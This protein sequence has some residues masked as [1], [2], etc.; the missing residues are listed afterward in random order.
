MDLKRRDFLKTGAAAALAGYSARSLAA[1]MPTG[2]DL[3][4]EIDILREALKLHPGL[5]RY[6]R[7]DE[8]DAALAKLKRRF[9]GANA[10]AAQYLLLSR[11]LA[12]I[13]CG[14]TYG[15]F[16][17]QK[18]TVA[19]DLFDRPTRLPF[20]FAWLGGAMIV[21]NDPSGELPAGTR[22]DELN[23]SDPKLLLQTL[24]P[25]VRADGHN[26]GKRISLLEVQGTETVETFDVFQGLVAPPHAG[27]HRIKST[28]PNGAVK[29]LE[30]PAI[31]LSERKKH[32]KRDA[33]PPD[34]ALWTWEQ[35]H[36]GIAILTMPTW[37]LYNSKWNWNAWLTERLD[38]LGSAKGLIVDLRDNEGGEDCGDAIL[39]RLIDK[40]YVPPQSE[41]RLRFTRTPA[42]IDKYLDTWDQSFRTLGVGA[43]PL[44]DGFYLRPGAKEIL[45]ITPAGKR[46]QL[47]IIVL[48]SPVDSSATFQFAQKF[49]AIRGGRLVGETTG[50]NRRGINGGCFFFVRLPASG[51]EFDLPLIGEFPL[52]PQP[53]AGLDPDIF[54]KRTPA[55]IQLGRDG[56][57]ERAIHLLS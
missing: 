3:S 30:L 12:G 41:Q 38:G 28:L 19:A 14:H 7:P 6:N 54:V 51:L 26:D 23:G 21:T 48:I 2:A 17:N 8:I 47:P 42:A 9:T 10:L 31:G 36:D 27:I 5:Y 40:P 11:F 25:L 53:D 24:L 1:D 46:L 4:G 50:G 56:A 16:F 35:R 33:P 37:A 39:A 45:S 20:N 32:M 49:R 52:A 57:L 43:K 13:R 18:K 44:A 22:I 29:R 15:N 34:G 55:D